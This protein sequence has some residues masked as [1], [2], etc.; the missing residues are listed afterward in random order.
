MRTVRVDEIRDTVARLCWEACYYLPS[1]VVQG[2]KRAQATEQSPIGESILTQLIDNA[3]LAATEA[4]PYCHDTGMTIVY[5]DLGQDVHI[6]GGSFADAI[7]EGVRRGYKEGYLRNSVVGDPLRRVNTGDNTPAVLHTEIVPGDRIRI[8]V[9]PKG[10]GSENMSAMKVLLPGEG[11][12][13]VK[14][15]V[16]ETVESAGG[17]ACPPLIVG[18]GI[19]GSFDKVSEIAKRAILRDIGVHHPEPHIAALEKQL[20]ELVN[21]TGIGPQGL[22]GVNTALWVAVETYA[23]HI[24]SLPVAVNLQC[25]A[26]R[27]RIAVL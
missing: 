9:L 26:A 15:F 11:E 25:H 7:Q 19:G 12:E 5:V 24:A 10:G 17:K 2:L 3:E 16:L 1:D 14:R 4:I 18:V 27:K 6:V 20:L 21:Q 8:T 23:C 13:G 22:G